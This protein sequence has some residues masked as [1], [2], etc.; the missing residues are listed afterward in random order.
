[1]TTKKVTCFYSKTTVVWYSGSSR[2]MAR[3]KNITNLNVFSAAGMEFHSMFVGA[4]NMSV[5]TSTHHARPIHLFT[6]GANPQLSSS[7]AS[8]SFRHKAKN[9]FPKATKREMVFWKFGMFSLQT[10]G[11]C[12]CVCLRRVNFPQVIHS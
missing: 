2:L 3:H 9:P 6:Q 4:P 1:M 7:P 11:L 10:A 12:D 8:G 5:D